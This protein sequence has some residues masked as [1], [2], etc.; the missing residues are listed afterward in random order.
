MRK[1]KI[2]LKNELMIQTGSG[3]HRIVKSED[4]IVGLAHNVW[5]LC[6]SYLHN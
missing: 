4:K 1:I 3:K 6:Y 5:K 2:V